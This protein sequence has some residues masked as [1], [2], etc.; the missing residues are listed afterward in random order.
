MEVDWLW[1]P[2][3]PLR[4]LACAV[5]QLLGANERLR[6]RKTRQEGLLLA[7]GAP[8]PRLL[9][10]LIRHISDLLDSLLR[11]DLGAD[12]SLGKAVNDLCCVGLVAAPDLDS[13]FAIADPGDVVL[14][15]IE[16]HHVLV[17]E[18][19]SLQLSLVKV[20]REC[21]ELKCDDFNLLFIMAFDSSL[22][23]GR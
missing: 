12:A 15:G 9:E 4:V 5:E 1:V 18:N 6:I 14:L 11:L 17:L 23:V 7:L 8:L 13:A 2:L 22:E 19:I 16:S 20:A 21:R 3:L 10:H